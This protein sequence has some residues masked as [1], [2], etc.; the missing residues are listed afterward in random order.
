MLELLYN[1]LSICDFAFVFWAF[2]ILI[3]FRHGIRIFAYT[4]KILFIRLFYC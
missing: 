4:V 2:D 3:I 1:S